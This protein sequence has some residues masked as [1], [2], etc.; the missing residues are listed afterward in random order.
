MTP[1]EAMIDAYVTETQ[2]MLVR[3]GDHLITLDE[4]RDGQKHA[5]LSHFGFSNDPQAHEGP[6]RQVVESHLERYDGHMATYLRYSH[7]VLTYLVFEDRLSA[8]GKMVAATRTGA[9]EF[10]RQGSGS[11]IAKFGRYLN[12]LSLSPPS[13]AE[14]EGLRLIRNCIVHCNGSVREFGERR[15]LEQFLANQS[16]TTIGPDDKLNLTTCGCLQLQ[17]AVSEYLHAINSAAGLRIWIPP[18]VRQSF[19]THILPHLQ[20]PPSQT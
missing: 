3:L 9:S 19:E 8:F 14:V 12:Q 1:E 15:A 11:L 6:A 17:E 13:A 7:V 2:L 18:Q 5:A 10:T 20:E 4:L 16:E